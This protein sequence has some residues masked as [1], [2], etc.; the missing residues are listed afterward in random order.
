MTGTSS[1]LTSRQSAPPHP[2]S[3]LNSGDRIQSG[4]CRVSNL[5]FKRRIESGGDLELEVETRM[6]RNPQTLNPEPQKIE[7]GAACVGDPQ[8]SQG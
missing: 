1:L 5:G 4:K 2:H 7:S 6:C 3:T 8:L